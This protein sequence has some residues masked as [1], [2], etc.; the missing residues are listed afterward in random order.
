MHEQ[1]L[2]AGVAV[3]GIDVGEAYGSPQAL[4]SFEALYQ[5]LTQHRGFAPKACLLG[6]SRGGLWISSWALAHPDRV[7]GMIGIYPVFDFRTYPGLTNAAPA[8]GLTPVELLARND[9]FNPIA[10]IERLAQAGIPV[11]LLHG[12]EDAVVPLWEN[13]AEF[14]RRYGAAQRGNLI[15]LEVLRGQGHNFDERFFNSSALV[16]FAIQHAKEAAEAEARP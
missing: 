10:R 3:A 13:S 14:A 5:E 4:P 8:Y 16:D 12:D 2:A 15:R 6:R 1:F 9:E 11:A 7:A